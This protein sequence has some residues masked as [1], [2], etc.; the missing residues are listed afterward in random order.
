MQPTSQTGTG[1]A[2]AQNDMIPPNDGR[3]GDIISM[4]TRIYG[5]YKV[6]SGTVVNPHFFNN[7]L[8]VG[9]GRVSADP[10][11]RPS[12]LQTRGSDTHVT[13]TVI[14]DYRL[15]RHVGDYT[16]QRRAGS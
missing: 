1:K 5:P 16:C 13:H 10:G 6:R 14:F 9:Y 7:Q 8:W 11:A 4:I 15:E 2:Y 12:P 3:L